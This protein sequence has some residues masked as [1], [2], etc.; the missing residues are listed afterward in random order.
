MISPSLQS[1]KIALPRQSR[2]C[3][4]L[5]RRTVVWLLVIVC[6]WVV[7]SLVGERV[8]LS[9][10]A[11][12]EVTISSEE[13]PFTALTL[14]QAL[15]ET[16]A[17]Q[18]QLV[19]LRSDELV[20]RAAWRAAWRF[21]TSLN[22]SISVEVSPW[23]F[24]PESGDH[25]KTDV[26]VTFLQPLELS[27]AQSARRSQARAEYSA[28][29]WQRLGQELRALIEVYRLYETAVYRRERIKLVKQLAQFQSN[30]AETIR[31]RVDAGIISPADLVLSQ[32][33]ESS[34]RQGIPLAEEEYHSALAEL[35]KHMGLPEYARNV[36]AV[37]DFLTPDKTIT[38]ELVDSLLEQAARCHP[39]VVA[40][41]A[42]VA[43][44]LAAWRLASAERIPVL[45]VGPTYQH[46]ESGVTFYGLAMEGTLPIINSGREIVW[47]R[48]QEYHRDLERLKQTRQLVR[49]RLEAALAKL[50]RTQE[51]LSQARSMTQTLEGHATKIADLYAAGQTDLITLLSVRR[52]VLEARQAELEL[53]WDV[54]KDYAEVLEASGG[55][56]LLASAEEPFSLR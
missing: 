20:A 46:D 11:P 8:C 41:E 6:L 38:Q 12:A 14:R 10:E 25:L 47:Q 30:L 27:G 54:T 52:R 17:R 29:Q 40:A 35:Q 43:A 42:Q 50:G 37:D 32:V 23:V 19:I 45:A 44:S 51:Q 4:K 3:R 15:Q 7:L 36:E 28:T 16:L 24:D 34:L 1:L 9:E 48:Q 53:T 56:G 49:V 33:E 39:D 26:A 22:P 31:R 55:L 5:F 18:P 21:P 13:S 2:G